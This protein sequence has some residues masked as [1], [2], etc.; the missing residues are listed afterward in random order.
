VSAELS[1]SD[2]VIGTQLASDC[3]IGDPV[4][5]FALLFVF[6][7]FIALIV[8]FVVPPQRLG[9]FFSQGKKK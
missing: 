8:L 9:E 2:D 1:W 3:T 4:A 6:L 5:L 7:I